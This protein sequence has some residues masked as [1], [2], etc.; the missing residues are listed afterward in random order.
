MGQFFL[1]GGF[2]MFPVLLFGCLFVAAAVLQAMRPDRK[3]WQ[4]TASLG[5]MNVGA[6]VLGFSMGII[7]TA[8][9][10][11]KVPAAEQLQV[12]MAGVGE[13]AHNLVLAMILLVIGAIAAAVGGFRVSRRPA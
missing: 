8:M 3:L 11:S 7:S 4:L 13:S 9:Y 1:E 6:G 5:A 10:L 2:G 12:A